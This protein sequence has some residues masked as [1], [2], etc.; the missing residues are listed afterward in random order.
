MTKKDSNSNDND[1]K[2]ELENIKDIEKKILDLRFPGKTNL[3]T[4]LDKVGKDFNVT[5]E[6]IKQIEA[7]ALKKLSIHRTDGEPPDDVA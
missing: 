3:D 1:N 2:N 5:R 6:R 7:K 4:D